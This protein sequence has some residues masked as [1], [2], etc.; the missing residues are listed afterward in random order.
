LLRPS[1]GNAAIAGYDLEADPIE[2]KRR[3][4]YVPETP[5]LYEALSADTF[6]DIVGSLYHLPVDVSERRRIELMELLGLIEVRHQRVSGLSKGM[7]QKVVLASALI[8]RPEVLILD[9]PFDG[10]DVSTT[11]VMKQVLRQLTADGVAVLF[12]SHVLEV[13]EQ[14]CTRISIIDR[15][16]LAAEGTAA[17]ICRRHGT[18]SLAEAFHALTGGR[19]TAAVAADIVRTLRAE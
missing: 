13:V 10:L 1:S 15:G 17:E 3:L 8:H 16:V 9:E 2:A 12:S 14:I 6:L 11:L 19:S 7:R 18:S 5:Q 4:G